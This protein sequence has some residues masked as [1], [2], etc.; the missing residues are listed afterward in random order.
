VQDIL[1]R[2]GWALAIAALGLFAYRAWNRFQISRLSKPSRGLETF[3][4]GQPGILYFT[5]PDCVPCKTQ[6]RPAFRKLTEDLSVN[7]QIIEIDATQY[8]HLADYW[9]V[10]SV[11][12]TFIIDSKL[13]PRAINHGVANAEKL[14]M[15]IESAESGL[16]S[17]SK[18]GVASNSVV[19][20]KVRSIHVE[21]SAK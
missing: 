9:G 10:L 3:L 4:P 5:T 18:K 15:Q 16:R 21:R 13:Q 6:Q 12:T 20:E 7:V 2:A 1:L 19:V 14:K 17:R 11:P 8:P